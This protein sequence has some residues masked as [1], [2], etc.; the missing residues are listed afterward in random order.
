MVNKHRPHLLVLPEDDANRQVANGFLQSPELN[1][2]AVQVLKPAG[3]WRLACEQLRR[4][5]LAQL[6][7][8]RTRYIVL[9]IDTDGRDDRLAEI[10]GEVPEPYRSRVFAVGANPEPE[11]LRGASGGYEALGRALGQDCR[12]GTFETWDQPGLVHNR[13]E[14]ARLA[15]AVSGFLFNRS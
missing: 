5:H 11:A 6:G 4:D 8:Y 9:L 14:V 3:G 7:I 12:T 10:V 13:P 2:C 15:E 1:L